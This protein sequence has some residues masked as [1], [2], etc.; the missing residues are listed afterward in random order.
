M[1]VNSSGT[2]WSLDRP[3]PR[4]YGEDFARHI[5][6]FDPTFCK[7]LVRLE[8]DRAL[9]KRQA[10]RL[11]RLSDFAAVAASC[12]ISWFR[13]RRSS[14]TGSGATREPTIVNCSPPV[15]SAL[16]ERFRI[17]AAKRT[18][19]QVRFRARAGCRSGYGGA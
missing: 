9:N 18:A 3:A 8:G 7:V 19:A 16:Y 12:S 10:A 14:S 11:K 17:C 5:E 15:S 13:R 1:E 6:A 4:A 2:G